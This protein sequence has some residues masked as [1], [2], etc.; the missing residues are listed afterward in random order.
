MDRAAPSLLVP[1]AAVVSSTFCF[2]IG[3][4]FAKDLFPAIGPAG[5]ACLRL[6]Y[7]A[8][9]IWAVSRPWRQWPTN[10][11]KLPMLGLGLSLAGVILFFYLAL[12]HLPLGIAVSLQFLGPLSIAI[13]ASRRAVDLVW[14]IIAAAGVWCLVGSGA[15]FDSIDPVG[16]FWALNA[17][18]CWA[19]YILFGQAASPAYGVTMGP[20]GMGLA[21]V[22]TLPI[23]LWQAGSALFDPALV[24]LAL[25]VALFSAAIPFSLQ[26]Y[27][28]PRMPNRTFA[29]FTSIEPAIGALSGFVMLGERLALI[30]IIGIA[31]VIIAAIGAIRSSA[32]GRD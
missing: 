24:P 15:G 19:G 12:E 10:T 27:A 28:L 25:G 20:I 17:A 14:A 13:F 16:L 5:A 11:P 2:Q 4:T 21:A 26:L 23:G 29:I 31:A 3:A 32:R 6:G 18:A 1:I 8:L 22:F 30:Q 9:M 7:A